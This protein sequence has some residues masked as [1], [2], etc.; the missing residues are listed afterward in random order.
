MTR[1]SL[2]LE[3][4]DRVNGSF[5]GGFT[6]GSIVLIE[7]VDG[8]GKSILSQR[9]AYGMASEGAS[10]SLVSTELTVKSFL[11]QMHSLSYNVSDLLLREQLLYLHA[12]ID[13]H[14]EEAGEIRGRRELLSRLC[15]PNVIW[16]GDVAV[17]DGFDAFLRNDPTFGSV[18]EAADEDHLMQKV[19]SFFR[20]Q[21]ARG[22]TIIVA[23]NHEVVTERAL[24]PLRDAADV[25]FQIE[26]KV[27]GPNIRRQVVVRRFSEMDLPVDDA[28]GFAVQQGRGIVIESRTVA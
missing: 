13:T 11:A 22:K 6:E 19:V 16:K 27:V 7:G 28:I 26:L 21:T 5:G 10:V 8:A 25:F 15:S 17:I 20:E 1:H 23:V 4:R 14:V 3:R 2:G 12:D 24:R 18:T 9:F